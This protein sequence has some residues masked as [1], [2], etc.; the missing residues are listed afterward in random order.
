MS[1]F[2]GVFGIDRF[3]LGYT[4]LGIVKLIT[5][6][7]LGIWALV[8]LILIVME[9]LP[10]A[11]GLPLAGPD[12]GSGGRRD[13]LLG[14]VL[15]PDGVAQDGPVLCLFRRVTE[16][17][18]PSCGLTRSWQAIGHGRQRG[19]GRRTRSVSSRCWRPCG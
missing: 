6:G 18:C 1:L 13:A 10:D 16:R 3:Y 17:P 8:D 14:A 2:V 4:G 15:L 12:A 7:G 11:N 19:S 5:C 9:R